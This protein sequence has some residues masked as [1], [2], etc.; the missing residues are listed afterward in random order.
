MGDYKGFR[1]SYKISTGLPS[2]SGHCHTDVHI[3]VVHQ[4]LA[5][6]VRIHI[7]LNTYMKKQRVN[8]CYN[9]MKK[10]TETKT[11]GNCA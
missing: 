4:L 7:G 8:L 6:H 9:D 5:L 2:G 11:T 1:R 10:I 3:I